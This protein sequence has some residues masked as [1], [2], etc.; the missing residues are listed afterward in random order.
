M[1]YGDKQIWLPLRAS[2]ILVM[3]IVIIYL[4][5]IRWEVVAQS[6]EQQFCYNSYD[7]RLNRTT[8]SHIYINH[9]HY[10][11]QEKKKKLWKKGKICIK[12][13]PQFSSLCTVS[14]VIE[15]KVVIG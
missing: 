3:V 4:L 8:W 14:V 13:K 5:L 7:Y 12:R 2:P 10:N 11:S 9:K 1:S 6:S 15:T